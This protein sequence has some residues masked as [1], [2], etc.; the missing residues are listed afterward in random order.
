MKRNPNH[1]WTFER[2][3]EEALKY[4]TK[5]EFN[6]KSMSACKVS[7]KNGWMEQISGHMSLYGSKYKRCIYSYEFIEDGSVYVGL[8]YN[9]NERQINRN[10][11]KK[12]QVTIHIDKTGYIPIRQQLTDYI[13]VNMASKLENK[14]LEKYRSNGWKILNI[15]KTGGIGGSTLY[16]T[17]EKCFEV[18]KQCNSRSEFQKKFRG[19]H[20]SSIKNGWIEEIRLILK[21]NKGNKI[22]YTKNICLEKSK[23]CKTRS[24]FKRKYKGEFDASYRNKWI[25][26]ITA[27]MCRISKWTKEDCKIMS[28]KCNNRTEFKLKYRK[29]YNASVKN[30]WVEDFFNK[31]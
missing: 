3:K 23:Q 5:K 13:D 17:K 9:I 8:T 11:D 25:N 21:C 6:E 22:K 18:V 12:D 4:A 31:K 29:Y 28:L 14:Y 1:Y 20:S 10:H 2:C 19:A 26:E 15:S 27:H 7:Y 30:N 24:E 16:W